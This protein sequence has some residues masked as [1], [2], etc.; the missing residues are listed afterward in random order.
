MKKVF[1]LILFLLGNIAYLK[2]LPAADQ[3]YFFVN[4]TRENIRVCCF[5]GNTSDVNPV[6][7][8]ILPHFK[9]F[10]ASPECLKYFILEEADF[11]FFNTLDS[12]GPICSNK[13]F[14]I[15]YYD[16]P[17]KKITVDVNEEPIENYN[18]RNNTYQQR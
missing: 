12:L 7:H 5:F 15:R 10:F 4:E 16:E 14:Y 8:D 1:T 2:A 6:C 18:A 3:K 11:P 9:T 13:T 17:N